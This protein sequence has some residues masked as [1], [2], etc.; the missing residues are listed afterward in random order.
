MIDTILRSQMTCCVLEEKKMHARFTLQHM[1][2]KYTLTL[3]DRA[4]IR[5]LSET[6]IDRDI[7]K[8]LAIHVYL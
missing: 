1:I 2:Y 7:K 6:I 5:T 3:K 4:P 8:I